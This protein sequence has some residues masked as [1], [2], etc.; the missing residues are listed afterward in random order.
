MQLH[1]MLPLSPMTFDPVAYINTPRWQQVSLGLERTRLLLDEL[2]N[3]ERQLKFIHVAGT[4]GKGSTCAYLNAICQAAGLRTGLFTSP[5][6]ERFEERIR[7]DDSEIGSEDLTQCT[8]AVKAAAEGVETATGE[9]PTEFELMCAVALLHFAQSQCD[10]CIMEVGLGGRLDSTNV[11]TPEVSIITR[12]GYDHTD[13]L[14]DTLEEI[15]AEKAGIIKQ[16]VPCVT[17]EQEPV[18][19][20]VIKDTC[21]EKH[22]PLRVVHKKDVCAIGLNGYDIRGF[23]YR[24]EGFAT[25]LLGSYQPENACLAIE[26]ARMLSEQGWS[27][28]PAAVKEGVLKAVWPGRLEVMS[29]TPLVIIDGAHNPDG[30][31]L[32]ARTLEEFKPKKPPV[33]VVGVLQDK[34]VEGI[35]E[36]HI[37]KGARFFTYAP[38]NPRALKAGYL[39]FRINVLDPE[40]D[41]TAYATAEEAVQHA[42]EEAAPESPIVAFGSLYS[43]ADVKRAFR[44]YLE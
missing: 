19:Q 28:S 18:V 34:D 29:R 7:I 3:P 20:Q 2:G 33:Y 37:Q 26:G 21:E 9:H 16:G 13:I 22:C 12:V 42:L 4:N 32:L 39:A 30:A 5:Y 15:A 24:G 38:C 41:V 35:L 23:A 40:A 10:I 25:H 27:I 43:I 31:E 44:S 17:C 1:Q 36:P 8:L 11:I 6:I 14:G